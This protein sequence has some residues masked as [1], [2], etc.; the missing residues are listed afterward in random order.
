M[1]NCFIV[2]KSGVKTPTVQ[3]LSRFS[4]HGGSDNTFVYYF[5]LPPKNDLYKHFKFELGGSTSV[6]PWSFNSGYSGPVQSNHEYELLD[7]PIQIKVGLGK[8]HIP[9]FDLYLY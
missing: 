6:F 3:F 9:S 7:S 8:A 1:G 5:N 2:R 4:Y